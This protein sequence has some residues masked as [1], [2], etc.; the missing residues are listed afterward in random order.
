MSRR[1]YLKLISLEEARRRWLGHPAVGPLPPETVPVPRA[2]GRVTAGP[3]FARASS[4]AYHCAAMDGVALSAESTFEAAETRPVRL[5]PAQFAVVD[6][7]D[8]IPEG[9]DAVVMVEQVR[10]LDGGAIELLQAAAPWQ[11]VRLAGEDLVATEMVLPGGHRLRPADLAALLACGVAEVAVR[12]RP[13]IAIL[14][15][16]DELFDPTADPAG[17]ERIGAIPE[18][19]SC[20]LAGMVEE[21]GGEAVRFPITPDRP[22]LLRTALLAAVESADLV[23]LNA[24]SSAGRE[25]HVPRLLEEEGELLAHGVEVMPGKPAALAVVRGKPVLGTPG[26]PVS[27][28]VIAE[29][30][31]VPALHQMQNLSAPRPRTFPAVLA[32]RT[33]SRIGMEERVRVRAARVGGRWT[34]VPLP[35]G[36]GLLSSLVR[37]DAVLPIPAALEGVDAGEEVEL[38]PLVDPQVLE[39]SLLAVGSHDLLLDLLSHRLGE[40]LPGA[41]LSSAHVGSLAGLTA[42]GRGECHLAG[43][44]LIDPDTGEYNRPWIER[45]GLAEEVVL[46]HLAWREQGLIVPAGNPRGITGL[47]DL[48]DG[49]V[50]YLNRQRGSGTRQLL[51]WLL[52]REGIDPSGIRGYPREAYTHLAVAEAVRTGGADCG[53]GILAAA[54]AL[55]LGFVPIAAERYDLAFR[56][57]ALDLPAAVELRRILEDPGFRSEVTALG[58]YDPSRSG[59][60]LDR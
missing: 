4:P 34:A 57:D 31:L 26:Y 36:A 58:G 37:A 23:V 20:L 17:F 12:R 6:T 1:R 40:R 42:L 53:M 5:D 22:E 45:L 60:V 47:A 13:R 52:Q 16:G 2:R 55:G 50:L 51:D 44:H 56:R 15:T 43:T 9:A 33:P 8:P 27:A 32:R 29:E 19:N 59:E 30:L 38:V 25:D 28:W 7:G 41:R 49:G 35:R 54:R 14:P 11:H 39:A 18:T 21:A 10:W 48:A 46:I 24:G 3:V